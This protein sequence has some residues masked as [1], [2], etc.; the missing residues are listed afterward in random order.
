MTPR[1][2]NHATFTNWLQNVRDFLR[3]ASTDDTH[4]G[5]ATLQSQEARFQRFI[6]GAGAIPG[7]DVA[8]AWKKKATL[9]HKI[10]TTKL[11]PGTGND[12]VTSCFS[13]TRSTD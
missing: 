3:I 2:R 10:A 12:P 4:R 8:S 7:C 6:R 1:R 5:K 13:D 9:F 11:V